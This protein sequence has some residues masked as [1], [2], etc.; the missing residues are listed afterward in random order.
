MPFDVCRRHR[1]LAR[2]QQLTMHEQVAGLLELKAE[3]E[4][5]V[6]SPSELLW[7]LLHSA[8]A[9]RRRAMRRT[10]RMARAMRT[11]TCLV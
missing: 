8:I 2:R 9:T 7:M 6:V 1:C 5:A 4:L 11:R 3:L 10:V